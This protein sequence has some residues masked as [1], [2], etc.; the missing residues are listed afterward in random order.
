M[1]LQNIIN[2][3]ILGKVI[4]KTL[5]YWLDWCKDILSEFTKSNWDRQMLETFLFPNIKL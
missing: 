2:N 3:E 4:A 5:A 1:T